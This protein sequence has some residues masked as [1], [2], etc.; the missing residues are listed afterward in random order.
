MIEEL[1]TK[2][3]LLRRFK[4]GD[5]ENVFR[6]LSNPEVIKYYGVSYKSLEAAREQMTWFMELEKKQTGGWWA[7]CTAGNEEFLGAAG[8][9]NLSK[10]HRKAELGFWL[11]PEFWGRGII[12]EVLPV[13]CSFAFEKL[14]LHRIE[15]F[16]ETENINSA[17]VLKKQHF[18]HEETMVDSEVKNGIFISV[19]IFAKLKSE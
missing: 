4:N 18:R 11:L 13:I 12:Q 16:V 15:A 9:N 8:F 7:I 3:F 14:N 6:G 1:G 2:R 19:D 5:L 17:K 10:E